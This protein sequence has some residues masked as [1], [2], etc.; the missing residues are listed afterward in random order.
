[1]PSGP[2]RRTMNRIR[3]PTAST[4]MQMTSQA[5]QRAVTNPVS[6]SRPSP[7]AR[8]SSSATAWAPRALSHSSRKVATNVSVRISTLMCLFPTRKCQIDKFRAEAADVGHEHIRWLTQLYFKH[9]QLMLTPLF[10]LLDRKKIQTPSS[11]QRRLEED[12]IDIGELE[13][14][15]DSPM[16]IV[17]PDDGDFSSFP[18]IHKRTVENLTAKGY[19][20]LFPIQ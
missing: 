3:A 16:P 6:T 4:A 19:V 8:P 11:S 18:E 7:S 17:T 15:A 10:S 14:V 13:Q 20:N 12:D 1:M 2:R 5:N 9:T